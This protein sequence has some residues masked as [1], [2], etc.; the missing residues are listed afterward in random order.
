MRKDTLQYI[1]SLVLGLITLGLV[2]CESFLE[3]DP[4][5]YITKDDIPTTYQGAIMLASAPYENWVSGGNLYGRWFMMW[6]TGTDD[7]SAQ[8]FLSPP[9]D[10]YLL[11][12]ANPDEQFY[13]SGIWAPLWKGVADCNNALDVIQQMPSIDDKDNVIDWDEDDQTISDDTKDVIFNSRI[14]KSQQE[15]VIAEVK[16]L[17]ALYYYHL[18]RMFGDLPLVTVPMNKLS[19]LGSI[20]RSDVMDIYNEV[21]IRDLEEAIPHL[22]HFHSSSFKGRFTKA[23]AYVLL[24]DVYLTLAGKRYSSQGVP[25]SGDSK[26]YPLAM[27]MADSAINNQGGFELCTT[28][29]AEYPN[30]YGQPWRQ[31]FSKESLIEFGN[32]SGFGIGGQGEGLM[33]VQEAMM[34]GGSQF[35]GVNVKQFHGSA[36]GYYLP[37][38]DLFRAFE[39]G[40]LR[41]EFGMLVKS[42][43]AEGDTCYSIPLY[44]KLLDPVIYRGETG[45]QRADGN[46]NIVLYR[47]ADA[48]LIYAE[49]SNEVNG[50]T[51]RAI[52]EI[53]QLRNRAGLED[54]PASMTKDEFRERIWQ[55]R[56][57]ELH[58]EGKRKFDLVRT[59]RLKILS[60]S[61]DLYYSSSDNPEWKSNS[62]KDNILVNYICLPY[63]QHEAIWP[64]PRPEMAL[65]PNWKQNY[66]Y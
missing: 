29:S 59:D 45:F 2:G 11:H 1:K 13:Y 43:D 35:W 64:I 38:P 14:T 12:N 7:Q 66:G 49:A 62:G 33:V 21:I 41:K 15:A 61:R 27:S 31:S 36:S 46:I 53:N 10:T 60:D 16:V 23:S 54:L 25:L 57:V 20:E 63:P 32:L 40:D 42:A 47:I 17:R 30:P 6:E 9:M 52:D 3:E 58:G 56:R 19:N 26:Y 50:P 5:G 18:V 22:Y 37:T 65:H 24:A 28:P 4:R 8:T 44:H 48:K 34:G 39:E 51:A 55:E